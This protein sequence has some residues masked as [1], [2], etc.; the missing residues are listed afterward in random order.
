MGNLA[1]MMMWARQ[2]KRQNADMQ[3]DLKRGEAKEASQVH[4]RAVANKHQ[5]KNI[6]NNKKQQP[7]SN[8]PNLSP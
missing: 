5:A 8:K 3:E 6:T 1:R 2:Q 4:V 7:I